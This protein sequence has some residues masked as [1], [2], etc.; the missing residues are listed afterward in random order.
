MVKKIGSFQDLEVRKESVRLTVDIYRYLK[1]CQDYVLKNQ[2]QRSAISVPSNIAERYERNSNNAFIQFPYICI[3]SCTEL[4]TQLYLAHKPEYMDESI[5][6]NLI[7]KTRK[8]Q[9]CSIN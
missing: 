7:E 3:S 8:Y 5:C 1:N 9:P 4:R 6:H 2:I